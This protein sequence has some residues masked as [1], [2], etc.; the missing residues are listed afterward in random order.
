[1]ACAIVTLFF[2]ESPV[3]TAAV[4]CDNKCSCARVFVDVV[5]ANDLVGCKGVGFRK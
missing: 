2:L 1:V 5:M 4:V 3:V